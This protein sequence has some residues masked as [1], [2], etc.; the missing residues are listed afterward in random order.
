MAEQ[1][2]VLQLNEAANLLLEECRTI[3]PGIQALF[4]FQLIAIFNTGFD[5][6]LSSGERILHLVAIGLTALAIVLIMT[7]AAYHR[8][9]GSTQLDAA[10]ITLA[11]R[12]VLLAMTPL[13]LGLTLDFYIVAVV[14]LEEPVAAMALAALLFV[15]IILAWFML[16]R[17]R[18]L[19]KLAGGEHFSTPTKA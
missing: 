5:D 14:I 4:G 2:K 19:Q 16:P 11:S 18:S 10:F 17:M 12:I 3:L 13:T 15:F 9:T 1:K 7:P 6:K 8:Q